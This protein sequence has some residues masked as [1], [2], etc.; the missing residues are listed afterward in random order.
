MFCTECGAELKSGAKFCGKCGSAISFPKEEE[1]GDLYQN[2]K[3]NKSESISAGLPE[4]GKFDSGLAASKRGKAKAQEPKGYDP[5]LARSRKD[6]TAKPTNDDRQG[7]YLYTVIFTLVA[8]VLKGG[9]AYGLG[10]VLPLSL[11]LFALIRIPNKTA[12][13]LLFILFGFFFLILAL[14]PRT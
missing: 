14:T 2:S 3:P 12:R 13:W 5:G 7:M 8:Y 9:G 4:Q 6:G 11:I 1:N 10:Y